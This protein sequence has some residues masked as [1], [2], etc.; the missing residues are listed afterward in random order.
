MKKCLL[1]F[2]W[3]SVPRDE[4]LELKGLLGYWLKLASRAAFRKGNN[5]LPELRSDFPPRLRPE[6][7]RAGIPGP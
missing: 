7:S 6:P 2:K 4:I 3:V 1:K 5:P